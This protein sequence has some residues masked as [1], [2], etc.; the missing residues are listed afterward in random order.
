MRDGKIVIARIF[1]AY[2]GPYDYFLHEQMR[3]LAPDRFES[4]V[5]YLGRRSDQPNPLEAGGY[6]CFYLNTDDDKGG[7]SARTL[8]G[9]R[10]LLRSENVDVVHC[11]RHEPVFYALTA[12][13]FMKEA[14][15]ILYH[16]HGKNRAVRWRRKLFYRLFGR[17]IAAF[18]AISQY[19]KQDIIETYP[20]VTEE[21]VVLLENSIDFSR[22]ADAAVDRDSMRR[23]FSLPPDAF[24]FITVGRLV[25]T[26]GYADLLEAF[27]VVR[28]QAP[29]AQL[30]MV[31]DGPLQS[32]FAKRIARPDLAGAVTLT[33]RREDVPQLLKSADA[34]VL[35]SIHEGFG[36]VVLEAMA[37]GRC[38]VVTDSGGPGDI[39]QDGQT[40]F[41]VPPS[42]PDRLAKAMLKV[43]T[44]S[45]PEKAAIIRRAA[46]QVQDKYTHQ[47][48][49]ARLESV[50]EQAAQSR[51]A[52]AVG[53]TA[54]LRCVQ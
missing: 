28:R 50:Y 30:V 37:A 51:I 1:K 16:V 5:I 33:G 10:R 22:Y 36:L 23:S 47:K 29:E 8:L 49:V 27:A 2:Q 38:T 17:R 35:S 6:R 18:L 44:L 7:F 11:M 31:G 26:K 43:L 9:L 4:L 48:A 24:V 34:F 39:V 21:K 14:P 41:I 52:G 53:K 40:G 3:M 20:T 15:A 13:M 32:Q 46:L 19:I 54:N 42:D 25:P 45:E 12:S